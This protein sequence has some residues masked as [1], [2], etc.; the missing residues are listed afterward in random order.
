MKEKYVYIKQPHTY[1]RTDASAAQQTPLS[2][3][4]SNEHV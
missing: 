1:Q 4:P 3:H 2:H